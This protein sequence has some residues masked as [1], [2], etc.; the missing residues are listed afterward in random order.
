MAQ[1]FGSHLSKG[2][3]VEDLLAFPDRI[4]TVTPEAALDAVR[5]VFAEDKHYIEAHLLPA[6]GDS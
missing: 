1:T 4:R 2:G 5:R 6:E 3:K